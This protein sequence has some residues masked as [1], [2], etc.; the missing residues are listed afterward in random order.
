MARTDCILGTLHVFIL[1]SRMKMKR[2]RMKGMMT[3]ILIWNWI[4]TPLWKTQQGIYLFCCER[5]Y[6]FLCHC[7]I[8]SD[9]YPV[10]TSCEIF[11]VGE[12]LFKVQELRENQL[13][14]RQKIRYLSTSFLVFI[15]MSDLSFFMIQ[16]FVH[17]YVLFFTTCSLIK[18]ILDRVKIAFSPCNTWC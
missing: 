3:L 8:S 15:Q 6:L 16:H 14:L 18:K 9:G 5:W 4:I 17:R 12:S 1:C 13:E 11:V 10:C 2:I 7:S